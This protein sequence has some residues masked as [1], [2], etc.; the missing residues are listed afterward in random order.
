LRNWLYTYHTLTGSAKFMIYSARC[1]KEVRAV[2]NYCARFVLMLIFTCVYTN[3][4][5]I[6]QLPKIDFLE[7]VLYSA[8][9]C[10]APEAKL[11]TAADIK[12]LQPFKSLYEKQINKAIY[13][14][15]P[16]IPKIIH[17]IWLGSPLPEKFAQ[18]RKT[19]QAL[20]PTWRCILW[21]DAK[22][23]QLG[24]VN[25]DAYCAASNYGEKSDIV[26][27]EILYR[28]GGLYVDTDFE[29]LKPFDV[30][31]HCCDFYTG[32]YPNPGGGWL[33][34]LNGLIGCMPKHPIIKRCIAGIKKTTHQSNSAAAII[35]RTGPD[36]FYRCI[37]ESLA[38]HDAIKTTVI[39]PPTFFYPWSGALRST[40]NPDFIMRFVRPESFAVHHWATSWTDDFN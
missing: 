12:G 36:Y 3:A 40:K 24:L 21:D 1:L 7:S 30:L 19:W 37:M 28:F 4:T 15:K 34:V 8:Q 16:R 35:S 25:G 33:Y 27:Y 9:Q 22:V 38:A 20:H 17:H 26:R 29:C 10:Y 2:K 23:A 32:S 31:H 18:Y 5:A 6:Q 14:K 11:I 13:R 39:F